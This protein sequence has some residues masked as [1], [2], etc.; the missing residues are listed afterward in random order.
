[1]FLYGSP[2]NGKTVIAEGHG[3]AL[4]GD[5]YMPYAIEVDG[6]I[7]TM[8]DPVNHE[9]LEGNEAPDSSHHHPRPRSAMGTIR[10]P[11][12]TVGGELTLDMLD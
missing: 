12:V 6:H 10:R 8:F 1:V 11:V 3:R 7:I 5:M 9:S 4:G 2:G